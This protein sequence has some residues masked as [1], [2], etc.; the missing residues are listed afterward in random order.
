MKD[1]I[2]A[3]S[4]YYNNKQLLQK[5]SKISLAMILIEKYFYNPDQ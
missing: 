4:V 1:V 5:R 2:A 3:T